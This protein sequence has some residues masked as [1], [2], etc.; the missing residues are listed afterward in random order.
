MEKC[1]AEGRSWWLGISWEIQDVWWVCDSCCPTCGVSSG[2][3]I[4]G[5]LLY[6][7]SRM[8][9]MPVIMSKRTI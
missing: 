2:A 5:P 1:P 7:G 3:H 8:E 9:P 6:S 4:G